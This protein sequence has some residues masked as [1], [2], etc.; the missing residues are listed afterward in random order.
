MND[1]DLNY[2]TKNAVKL[3][4]DER[5]TIPIKDRENPQ[6]VINV[7]PAIIGEALEA[8][9]DTVFAMSTTEL[10][11]AFR[12]TR[13][14]DFTEIEEKLRISFWKEYE[15]AVTDGRKMSIQR[16]TTGVCQLP[17]FRKHICGS[18]FRLAYI[19]TPPED[20]V[21]TL[22]E[23][24]KLATEQIRDI[25]LLPHIKKNGEPDARMA[26]VKLKILE[27]MLNRVKGSVATRVESKNL[28]VNI[29]NDTKSSSVV[30]Q[31]TSMEDL[32]K[33]LKELAKE[34]SASELIDVTPKP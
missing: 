1:R 12:K 7:A 33:K 31:I 14:D 26:D 9:P 22:E 23:L 16:I 8:I 19:L 30:A 29:E 24:L 11:D 34:V 32:D 21:L 10:R 5:L 27:S 28:N 2:L 25:L 17:F 18:S 3:N 15:S 20:Y 6:S 4:L 13:Y